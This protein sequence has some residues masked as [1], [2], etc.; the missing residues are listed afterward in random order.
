MQVFEVKDN[1]LIQVCEYLMMILY[2]ESKK[3]SQIAHKSS[4]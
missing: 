4:E 1:I 3:L 2:K